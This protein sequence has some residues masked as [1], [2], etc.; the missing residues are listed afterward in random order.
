MLETHSSVGR[1]C[2]SIT[3]HSWFSFTPLTIPTAAHAHTQR[4][5][6]ATET[7]G[8]LPLTTSA[9]LLHPRKSTWLGMEPCGD[10]LIH[11]FFFCQSLVF[12]FSIRK[13]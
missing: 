6:F 4:F 13:K 11:F 7:N 1:P 10:I 3:Y 8:I 2:A 5:L 12:I 9:C